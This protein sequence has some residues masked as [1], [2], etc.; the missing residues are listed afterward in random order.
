[1]RRMLATALTAA[2]LVGACSTAGGSGGTIEGVRW[3]A[4]SIAVDGSLQ[5]VQEGVTADAT[6]TAG[7]VA[8]FGGCNSYSGPARVD[9]SRLTVG[10]LASTMM[11]CVDP[12]MAVEGSYLEALAA[13]ASYTATADKLSLF[14]KD[15]REIVVYEPGPANPLVGRWTVSGYDDG[16]SG[17]V[18]PMAGAALTAIFAGHGTVS[19]SSGCNTYTGSYGIDG[20]QLLFGPLATTKKACP[21]PIMAQE[22]AFLAALA[23]TSTYA[24]EAGRAVLRSADGAIAV[25]L[26][27]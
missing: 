20:D 8:G 2:M 22:R 11:A 26:A 10:P 21:D 9:G 5:A 14:D 18:R 16:T 1:M 7:K 27:K 19:G 17:V 3:I 12:A 24:I 25:S 23:S 15:G 4:T 6:F 13:V